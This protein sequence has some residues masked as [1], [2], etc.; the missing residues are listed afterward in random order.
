MVTLVS[1]W[2][3]E[4]GKNYRSENAART[5]DRGRHVSYRAARTGKTGGADGAEGEQAVVGEAN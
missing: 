5:S 3:T 1:L 4:R 2:T